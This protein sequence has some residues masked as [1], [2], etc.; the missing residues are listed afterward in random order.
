[1]SLPLQVKELVYSYPASQA[2]AVD[3]ISFDVRPGEIV[4][5][6]G[7]NGAGKTTTLHM[8]LGLLLPTRGEVRI[9]GR[10]PT[11][12]GAVLGRLNFASVDVQLPSNLTVFEALDIFARLYGTPDRR[13]VIDGW[14]KKLDLERFR[15]QRI[16]SL[17]AG[18]HMR[19]KIGKALL[20]DPDLLVL[21]EP[22]LSLDPAMA[23]QVRSIL[24]E[25]QRERGMAMLHTSHNMHEVESFCDR[26]VFLHRGKKLAEGTPEA[27]V[28]RFG[29][30]SLQELFIRV[31]K[32]GE[33]FAE[34]GKPS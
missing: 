25:I 16:G 23:E 2:P 24:K 17:S 22:T 28:K 18:E 32:S 15:S 14:L 30:S 13:S 4:G 1:M 29:S 20:N 31:A 7:P 33:L 12:R 11:D 10:K 5:L 3:G 27:V 26:I 34:E 19:L 6:L 9:F 21:D 8:V